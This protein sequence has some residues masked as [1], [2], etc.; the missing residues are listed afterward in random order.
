MITHD[1]VIVGAGMAGMRAALEVGPGLDVAV[2]SKMHPL[3]S[4]TGAAQG[5]I[6]ASLGNAS[7]DS[8]E[9]HM[10][11]TVKGSDYLGD[12]DAIEILVKEA[13]SNIYRLEHMGVIFSRTEESKIAQRP[14]GGH[15]QPRACY[16]EDKTGHVLLHT[17]FEQLLKNKVKVYSEWYVISLAMKDNSCRGVVAY[18]IQ[19]GELNI[20]RAKAVMFATGGYGRAFKITS[21]ALANTGDGL[22]IAYRAGI[23]LEDMEF[24]QFHPTGLYQQGILITEGARGE[25]GY[26]I[27]GKGERFMKN[28]ASEKMEL[29]PRDIIARAEQT[30]I[31]EGRGVE[32]KDYLHLDLRHL[33]AKKINEKLPQIHDL[34]LS[35]SGVDC[36]KEPIPIQ[37][38]AHY[39]MGG[40]P[41]DINGRVIG[42]EGF[43]AAGECS[44]ISI[45]GA[46]R[47]GTNSLLDATVFGRR[48]GGAMAKYVKAAA[49]EPFPEEVA[50]DTQERIS[51]L[52]KNKGKESPAKIRTELQESM[53]LNCGIFRNE[54]K[55][56]KELKIIKDLQ[57]RYRAIHIDDKSKTFNTA[58][59]EALELGFLLEFTE[60]IVVSA[61]ARKESRGAHFRL[62]YPERNDEQWLKHTLAYATDDG[63]R[64]EYKSVKIT[65][66]P[67]QKRKY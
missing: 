37:P 13:P 49:L 65:K 39:S 19:S 9:S 35:F 58:L 56:K 29:A 1:I 24:V 15:S 62:D 59:R 43:F 44:C 25:G 55:L 34:A 66:F 5:G 33:G 53:M 57:K 8:W 20:I 63:P 10:F 28:Y 3:R 60:V 14:F 38:A 52:L 16:A 61:L 64:L 51:R 31:D 23:P 7:E 22:G 32:G 54:K 17:L 4:H 27:N 47:L 21:N 50:K 2:I 26:L 11:D 67:P 48:A 41:I 12:Q 45:H 40:I 6:A 42:T 18:D 46:N 36:I 30:E